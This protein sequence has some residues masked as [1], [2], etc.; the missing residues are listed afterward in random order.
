MPVSVLTTTP[1]RYGLASAGAT[2]RVVLLV[3][4][5]AASRSLALKIDGTTRLQWDGV[6]AS[7]DPGFT[8]SVTLV[9]T[10][11][12]V[13]LA[14]VGGWVPGS[15][16]YWS[17]AYGDSDTPVRSFDGGFAQVAATLV[18]L[19]PGDGESGVAWRPTVY[20]EAAFDAGTPLSID[21]DVGGAPAARD[22]RVATPE[23][24]GRTG[25]TDGRGFV[26][27]Q[28]RR[29]FAPAAHVALVLRPRV[30]VSGTAYSGRF[31]ATFS[32]VDRGPRP[33]RGP[34]L[35]ATDSPVRETVRQMAASALR[36]HGGSPNLATVLPFY[37]R[38]S[39]VGQ[40]VLLKPDVRADLDP[41]DV[42]PSETLAD[43]VKHVRPLWGAL[44]DT[45][46]P[47]VRE[48]LDRA[49]ASGHVIEQVGALAVVLYGGF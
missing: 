9:D 5:V 39:E 34:D 35:A 49:W 19:R 12:T 4:P 40:L 23:F 25:V 43:L 33:S 13:E 11:L 26:L 18:E 21:L 28:P 22:G 3:T 37:L 6:S 36:P 44:L 1:E 32:T 30:E 16:V 29:A 17:L 38:R 14:R 45:C 10:T 24:W 31:E 47:E 27:V 42:P 8:G 15:A 46:D 2:L 20:A 7:V 41:V 48:S